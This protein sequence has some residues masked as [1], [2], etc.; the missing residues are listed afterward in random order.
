MVTAHE[1]LFCV[2][3]LFSHTLLGLLIAS[4][5]NRIMLCSPSSVNLNL[6]VPLDCKALLAPKVDKNITV[7]C[8]YFGL[9]GA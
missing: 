7:L 4:Y 5:V 3:T 9:S 8:D 6:G 1:V 2:Y